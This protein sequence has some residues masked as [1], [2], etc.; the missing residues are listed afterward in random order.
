MANANSQEALN[1]SGTP[2]FSKKIPEKV[3]ETINKMLKKNELS[4]LN[5]IR[6][7]ENESA[8]KKPSSKMSQNKTEN[9]SKSAER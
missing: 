3:K 8:P 7:H 9:K 2:E 6:Y 5:D 4:G 1:H